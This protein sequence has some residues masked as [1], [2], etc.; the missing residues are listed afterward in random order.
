MLA[1]FERK[2]LRE[3]ITLVQKERKAPQPLGLPLEP[4]WSVLLASNEAVHVR[5]TQHPGDEVDAVTRAWNKV[6]DRIQADEVALFLT[7]EPSAFYQR[8]APITEAIRH[9]GIRRVIVGAEDPFLRSKGKGIESLRRQGCDVVLADGE[10]ARECQLFYADYEKAVNR[11][12]PRWTIAWELRNS[13]EGELPT[14]Q[15]L[16]SVERLPGF[17]D[18]T[19][20]EYRNYT[21]KDFPCAPGSILL[22]L[23]S[24]AGLR[25]SH[26]ALKKNTRVIEAT[27]T[28]AA[29]DED[30]EKSV[31]K[32]LRIP[33]DGERIDIG[34]L[35]RQVRDLSAISV[36]SLDGPELWDALITARI[37]DRVLLHVRKPYNVNVSLIALTESDLA[38]IV[39]EETLRYRLKNPRLLRQ[40]EGS[41][42]VESE[43]ERLANS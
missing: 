36:I 19:C 43:V 41:F 35:A 7:L 26:P 25:T 30:V 4:T 10:E 1:E 24:F 16:E 33:M 2:I 34:K 39:G 42:W 6:K 22:L 27:S 31:E 20:A 18:I 5:E 23:D 32:V 15:S 37:A 29:L 38:M 14:V 11:F 3:A 12:L 17:F 13:A 21:N 28:D 8:L 9:S 40:E